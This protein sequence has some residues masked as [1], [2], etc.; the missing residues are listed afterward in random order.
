MNF[1]IPTEPYWPNSEPDNLYRSSNFTPLVSS[2]VIEAHN[3][4][5]QAAMLTLI[6]SLIKRNLVLE[7]EN[8]FLRTKFE[9]KARPSDFKIADSM[10]TKGA[11]SKKNVNIIDKRFLKPCVYCREK[12][13]YGSSRCKGFGAICAFCKGHNHL[14]IACF[15]KNPGFQFRKRKRYSNSYSNSKSRESISRNAKLVMTNSKADDE[16]DRVDSEKVEMNVQK[17]IELCRS[18]SSEQGSRSFDAN[19]TMQDEIGVGKTDEE[20]TK[21]KSNIE[22]NQPVSTSMTAISTDKGNEMKSRRKRNR[23]PK[24]KV[25]IKDTV[26]YEVSK[27]VED[28]CDKTPTTENQKDDNSS[29]SN[30]EEITKSSNES[31]SEA[32][33]GIE[34]SNHDSYETWIKTIEDIPLELKA[35]KEL[36]RCKEV[37]DLQYTKEYKEVKMKIKL[38][39]ETLE[40]RKS[41]L[42]SKEKKVPRSIHSNSKRKEEECNMSDQEQLY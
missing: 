26:K 12:H 27:L 35:Y 41:N 19:T 18:K 4:E 38:L 28:E 39:E 21:E 15:Y 16:E 2:S 25:G 10:Q 11:E 31:E 42:V 23:K 40:E 24:K 17:S 30:L 6:S 9:V 33:Y 20:F 36:I 22:S 1:K 32:E 13:I 7:R 8:K 34:F 14:E 5:E 37:L 3:A 29:F